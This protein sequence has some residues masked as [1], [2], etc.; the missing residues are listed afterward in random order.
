[1][2]LLGLLA[3]PSFITFVA[4]YLG[5][6]SLATYPRF[7]FVAYP[8]IYTACAVA[9]VRIARQWTV[10]FAPAAITA[11]AICLHIVLTNADVFGHPWLYYLFYYQ[12][13]MLSSFMSALG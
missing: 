4:L 11:F 9:I 10:P 13:T 2:R 8:A 1:L 3:L 12:R 5:Q 7:V 6:T